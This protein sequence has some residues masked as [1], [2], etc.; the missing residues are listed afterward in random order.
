MLAEG[1]KARRVIVVSVVGNMFVSV[2]L[3]LEMRYFFYLK[4]RCG[5]AGKG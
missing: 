1:V 4:G 5:W 2:E 3:S